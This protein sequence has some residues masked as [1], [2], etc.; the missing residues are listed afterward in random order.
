M[1]GFLRAATNLIFLDKMVDFDEA[2]CL[3]S[4]AAVSSVDKVRAGIFL[5]KWIFRLRSTS[6]RFATVNLAFSS[7]K[8]VQKRKLKFFLEPLPLGVS[9]NFFLADQIFKLFACPT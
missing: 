7:Q 4:F 9:G 8:K 2:V 3:R 5:D 1:V 6:T